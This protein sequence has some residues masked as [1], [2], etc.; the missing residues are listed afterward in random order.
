MKFTRKGGIE[1]GYT[2]KDK[3]LEFYVIDAGIGLPIAMKEKVFERFHQVDNTLTRGYEGA[4]LGLSITKGFVEMLGGNI[5]VESVVGEGCTFLFTLEYTPA[6]SPQTSQ[7][8]PTNEELALPLPD[9]TLLIAEDDAMSSLLLTKSLQG[10]NIHI[11]TADHGQQ[12]VELVRQHPEIN[13]GV[14]SGKGSWSTLRG[15]NNITVYIHIMLC[16]V[17]GL[18]GNDRLT[19]RD[20]RCCFLE[21]GL[22]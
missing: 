16:V 20:L 18:C 5:W 4:G 12:A 1:F 10:E 22:G 2:R 8:F 3:L 15:Y 14:A 7:P 17:Q 11:L 21:Q 19:Y 13:I 9:V 6:A